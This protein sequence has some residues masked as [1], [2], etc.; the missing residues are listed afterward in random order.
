[1]LS[2]QDD[3]HNGWVF[4]VCYILIFLAAPILYVGVVQ[5]TLLDKLGANKTVAN[6]PAATY[7][8]GQIAPLFFSWL[9]PHR[10]ERQV[11]V[12]ANAATGI[13][14]ALVFMTLV[15]PCPAEVR[16]GAVVLQG[17]LQG[18]SASTSFVFMVG[19]LRRGTSEQGLALTLKRTFTITPLFAVAG[20]LGAQYLLNPGLPFLPYPFDF[21]ALHLIGTLAAFSI[22]LNARRFRLPHLDD[23]ARQP[24]FPFLIRSTREFFGDRQMACLWVGYVLWYSSLDIVSNLSLYTRQ[25]MGRDPKDFSGIIMA[26]RF[27][28]KAIGGW[29]LGIMA[30]RYGLRSAVFGT[31]LLV[32][33]G[34]A[35]AWAV[36]GAG[37]L[38]SFGLLGAGE[39]GGAYFPNFVSSLSVAAVAPRNLAMITLATSASSFA[40]VLHGY[41]TDRFGFPASFALGIATGLLAFVMVIFAGPGKSKRED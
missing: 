36:D 15:V 5:A 37:Y 7:M 40:P 22:A 26:I 33:A 14:I 20:S 3:R 19:C 16:I 9:V 27:G 30:V 21:A 2:A 12:W 29:M 18:L 38:F 39:L 41:L 35:W 10:L 23:E 34:S 24:L 31:A 6:L 4:T 28:C 32:A 11:V 17:L 25:A 13:V 1:M 8:L